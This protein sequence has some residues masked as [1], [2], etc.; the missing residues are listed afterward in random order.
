MGIPGVFVPRS[1]GYWQ[2]FSN[3]RAEVFLFIQH[4]WR[5]PLVLGFALGGSFPVYGVLLFVGS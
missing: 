3:W 4:S 2:Y 5:N 1:A